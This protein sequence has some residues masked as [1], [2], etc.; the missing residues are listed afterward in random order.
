LYYN[1][2]AGK[3]K[4]LLDRFEELDFIRD[5]TIKSYDKIGGNYFEFILNAKVVNDDTK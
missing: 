4:S 2:P 1:S 5:M 3:F